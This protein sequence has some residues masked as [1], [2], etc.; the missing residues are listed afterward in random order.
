MQLIKGTDLTGNAPVPIEIPGKYL[1]GSADLTDDDDSD[2]PVVA[3]KAKAGPKAKARKRR[4]A[5][6]RLEDFESGRRVRECLDSL[7]EPT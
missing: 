7:S 3:P 5:D 2:D 4:R 1:G 6:A